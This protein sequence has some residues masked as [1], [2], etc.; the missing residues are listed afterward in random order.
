MDIE[1]IVGIFIRIVSGCSLLLY[2]LLFFVICKEK[3]NLSQLVKMQLNITC[4]LHSVSFL[5]PKTKEDTSAICVIGASLEMFGEFSKIA[6]ST[7]IVLLSQLNFLEHLIAEKRKKLYV[8]LSIIF[9]WVIPITVTIFCVIYGESKYYSDFCWVNNVILL[10]IICGIKAMYIIIFIV[11]SYQL[12]KSFSQF[13]KT[14]NDEELYNNFKN[15]FISYGVL[16]SLLIIIN[17]AYLITDNLSHGKEKELQYVVI[18]AIC[19]TLNGLFSPAFVIVF[20]IDDAIKQKITNLFSCNKKN[21]TE[22]E[23]LD[24]KNQSFDSILI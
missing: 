12:I 7:T 4:F 6:I 19:D 2:I 9:T 3:N 10:N 14:Q 17:I 11:L 1:K 13:F 8:A 18:Y 23:L 5:F 20:I 16:N 21:N 15:K 24:E 22:I